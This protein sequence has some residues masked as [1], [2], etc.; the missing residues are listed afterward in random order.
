MLE[1]WSYC[2]H[3]MAD[4]SRWR[5]RLNDVYIIRPAE[6]DDRR[7]GT[8]SREAG[9]RTDHR[10]DSSI[11]DRITGVPPW[12]HAVELSV[13]VVVVAETGRASRGDSGVCVRIVCVLYW[14]HLATTDLLWRNVLSPEFGTKSI[15]KYLYFGVTRI[16]L[17]QCQKSAQSI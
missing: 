13:V 10:T 12:R 11:S 7:D 4:R 8:A 15:R 9:R 2:T 14:Q 17:K 1:H 5:P 6:N 16:S 3:S